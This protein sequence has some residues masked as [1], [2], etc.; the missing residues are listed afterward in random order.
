MNR[1][2]GTTQINYQFDNKNVENHY[3]AEYDPA[4]WNGTNT[5]LAIWTCAYE[6]VKENPI[7]GTGLGDRTTVL[8]DKYKEKH[9]LYAINTKK[10]THNQYLDILISMGIIGLLLFLILYF[11][12]PAYIYIK[13]KNYFALYI[14]LVL[15]ICMFT[16]NMFDRYQGLIL[17]PFILV[18]SEK[19]GNKNVGSI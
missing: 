18:L 14:L 12:F 19:V 13:E 3:N 11:I 6:I 2:N 5:R 4:K 7:L 9:F 17:I 16:E 10:N 1:F 15:A 8:M